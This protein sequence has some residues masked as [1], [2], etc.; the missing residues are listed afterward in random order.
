MDDGT[1]AIPNSILYVK[2]FDS[3]GSSI[4]TE[5][6]IPFSQISRVYDAGANASSYYWSAKKSGVAYMVRFHVSSS[7]LAMVQFHIV[8]KT[9]V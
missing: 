4:G 6:P 7:N 1:I 8:G 5:T 9:P 3:I 2:S